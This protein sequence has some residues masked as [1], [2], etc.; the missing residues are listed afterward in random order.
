[1]ASSRKT[2]RAILQ[3]QS[4]RNGCDCHKVGYPGDFRFR[5]LICSICRHEGAVILFSLQLVSTET[6]R[7][8]CAVAKK[9]FQ[10]SFSSAD[11]LSVAASRF[12]CAVEPL[13]CLQPGRLRCQAK[14]LSP[15]NRRV[16]LRARHCALLCGA[17]AGA[18]HAGVD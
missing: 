7:M 17:G 8:L 15:A 12:M 18:G 3:E 10:S 11:A 4:W 2:M 5:M 6:V 14:S 13:R 16:G 1:S 9:A